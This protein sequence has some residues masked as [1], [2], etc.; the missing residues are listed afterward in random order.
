M[1][2]IATVIKTNNTSLSRFYKN[3]WLE[4]SFAATT[5]YLSLREDIHS[6]PGLSFNTGFWAF[7][8]RFSL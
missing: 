3:M 5:T 2:L 1:N 7:I 4:D 8:H 6:F